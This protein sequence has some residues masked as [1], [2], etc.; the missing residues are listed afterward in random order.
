MRLHHGPSGKSPK[1]PLL[2]KKDYGYMLDGAVYTIDCCGIVSGW[3]AVFQGVAGSRT[4]YFQVWRHETASSYRL[5][6]QNSVTVSI[7]GEQSF[8]VPLGDRFTVLAGDVFGW[9]SNGLDIITYK[10]SFS[11]GSKMMELTAK[12]VGDVQDWTTAISDT[13]KEYAIRMDVSGGSVPFFTN[14]PDT[15]NIPASTAVGT[16]IFTV[17]VDDIDVDQIGNLSVTM[18]SDNTN[19]TFDEVTHVLSTNTIFSVSVVDSL[20]FQVIDICG[21]VSAGTLTVVITNE[22]PT[23]NPPINP[24]TVGEGQ[25]AETLLH[26]LNVTD[27]ED[28]PITCSLEIVFPISTSFS[29]TLNASDYGIYTNENPGFDYATINTYMLIVPCSDAQTTSTGTYIVEITPNSGPPEFIN[30]PN[31]A[32]VSSTSE[33]GTIIFTV[34]ANDTDVADTLSYSMTCDTDPCLFA[35]SV[36]TGVIHISEDLSVHAPTVYN[37]VITVTDGLAMAESKNLTITITAVTTTTTNRYDRGVYEDSRE[38]AKLSTIIVVLLSFSI[39]A[40]VLCW[41]CCQKGFINCYKKC[42]NKIK[43]KFCSNKAKV[44]DI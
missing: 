34:L 8:S 2:G 16:S 4:V 11:K 10:A 18:T 9:W 17:S 26:I 12:S 21:S 15:V 36:S 24:L 6:G 7:D 31:T 42:Y 38:V 40:V 30:L 43:C 39:P 32:T 5:I 27:P 20:T 44:Q 22:G 29:V 1:T 37:L 25:T 23:L 28:D 19:Y 14:L 3:E 41:C 13:S 33:I 35:I